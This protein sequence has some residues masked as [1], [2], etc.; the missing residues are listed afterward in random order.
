[1][2]SNFY[3]FIASLFLINCN[4]TG[5]NTRSPSGGSKI[6]T[7]EEEKKSIIPPPKPPVNN[8]QSP[9]EMGNETQN[10]DWTF[11]NR[12]RNILLKS[13]EHLKLNVMQLTNESIL[14]KTTNENIKL[15]LQKNG[16]I[17]EV[18]NNFLTHINIPTNKEIFE[19]RISFEL[20]SSIQDNLVETKHIPQ[21]DFFI[22]VGD[23]VHMVSQIFFQHQ[24][25]QAILAQA[26]KVRGLDTAS[27]QE[28][29]KI[30]FDSYILKFLIAPIEGIRLKQILPDQVSE[31]KILVLFDVLNTYLF[32]EFI[33]EYSKIIEKDGKDKVTS[34]TFKIKEGYP[35]VDISPTE[36]Y[37]RIFADLQIKGQN[38]LYE[39]EC[40]TLGI[41]ELLQTGNS[42]LLK[43]R[44]Y[45]YAD[46]DINPD[47]SLDHHS[48]Y[49]LPQKFFDTYNVAIKDTKTLHEIGSEFLEVSKSELLKNLESTTSQTIGDLIKTYGK[50][51]LIG[52][53]TNDEVKSILI[54]RVESL[55]NLSYES[56]RNQSLRIKNFNFTE[57]LLT[58]SVEPMFY[59]NFGSSKFRK[60]DKIQEINRLVLHEIGHL[61]GM[62][63][64]SS[65]NF[66]VNL[67]DSFKHDN[68][69]TIVPE[70]YHV[71]QRQ[72]NHE[73]ISKI[74]DVQ[75]QAMADIQGKAIGKALKENNID[76][77]ETKIKSYSK[78]REIQCYRGIEWQQCEPEVEKIVYYGQLN[79]E[80]VLHNGSKLSSFVDIESEIKL[81]SIIDDH[82]NIY[83]FHTMRPSTVSSGNYE[84]KV[85]MPGSDEYSSIELES[86]SQLIN[87]IFSP[88]GENKVVEIDNF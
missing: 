39:S 52:N 36:V 48:L 33:S 71:S 42:G 66:S 19:M 35:R 87:D 41:M 81:N 21:L 24:A 49:P 47:V 62:D 73:E 82:G 70:L 46:N 77:D 12:G 17:K 5:K 76:I 32:Y 8:P 11:A 68:D 37:A 44:N 67:I 58:V 4:T 84:I 63:D 65:F 86:D 2:K 13:I 28:L 79:H 9:V 45:F 40:D 83:S 38:S 60:R 55:K 6:P 75:R 78:V 27:T 85:K 1:M 30:I 69:G 29:S 59:I 43:S 15:F 23:N 3:I 25:K 72:K 56:F 22:A 57:D 26:F 18:L 53:Q 10:G 14:Q 7:I 61:Y 74:L 54:S 20:F 88:E 31:E 34:F 80:F 50:S 64:N 16:E 51:N